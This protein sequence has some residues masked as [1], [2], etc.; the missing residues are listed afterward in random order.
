MNRRKFIRSAGITLAGIAAGGSVLQN[1]AKAM[2]NKNFRQTL[3][4]DSK[5]KVYWGGDIH[6]HCNLT[7]GHG[8]MQEAFEAARQ[9]L[10]FVSITPHAMWPDI[11]GKNDPRLEWVIEYHESAFRRLRTGGVG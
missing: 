10:D 11:P 8:G 9:Q 1:T 6:N 5:L 2:S 4:N 7:Y 3:A